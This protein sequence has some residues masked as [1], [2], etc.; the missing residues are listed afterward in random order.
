[1]LFAQVV[2]LAALL[3]ARSSATPTENA[4]NQPHGI[5]KG[6]QTSR[7]SS[8]TLIPRGQVQKFRVA[9]GQ[10]IQNGDGENHWVAW[11][12]GEDACPGQAVLGKLNESPCDLNFFVDGIV[13]G[14]SCQ[15]GTHNVEEVGIPGHW[16]SATC[17]PNNVNDRKI[18]CSN[19]HD[20]VQHGYCD[21]LSDDWG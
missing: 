21:W 7:Y 19:Q 6:A 18:H 1:M 11:L 16:D 12:H 13:V 4:S 14:F 2:A 8:P 9:W 15:E 10:Q 5:V 3:V 20:I 17:G